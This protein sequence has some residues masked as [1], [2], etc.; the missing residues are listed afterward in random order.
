M[1]S[2]SICYK[3]AHV[4][5]SI[6]QEPQDTVSVPFGPEFAAL[7]LMLAETHLGSQLVDLPADEPQELGVPEFG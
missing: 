7:D 6:D 4:K 2:A 3:E 1:C 5:K